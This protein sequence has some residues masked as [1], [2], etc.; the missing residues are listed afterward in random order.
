MIHPRAVFDAADAAAQ[1]IGGDAR[2]SLIVPVEIK[3]TR[4][5]AGDTQNQLRRRGQ[6]VVCLQGHE[7]TSAGGDKGVAG[8]SALREETDESPAALARAGAKVNIAVAADGSMKPEEIAVASHPDISNEARRVAG[9]EVDGIADIDRTA[10]DDSARAL[11]LGAAGLNDQCTVG[12]IS[13]GREGDGRQVIK[14]QTAAERGSSRK[15]NDRVGG[16]LVLDGGVRQDVGGAGVGRCTVDD[17]F[18]RIDVQAAALGEAAVDGQGAGARLGKRS[19][20]RDAPRQGQVAGGG[21]RKRAGLNRGDGGGRSGRAAEDLDIQRVVLVAGAGFPDA[22]VDGNGAR[23]ERP[24]D[25]RLERAAAGNTG[26]AGVGIGRSE[27]DMAAAVERERRSAVDRAAAERVAHRRRAGSGGVVED[28]AGGADAPALN[29]DRGIGG[30][31]C[32]QN[33]T[34][35]RVGDAPRA[36]DQIGPDDVA[37]HRVPSSG[38]GTGILQRGHCG[39]GGKDEVER[40]ANFAHGESS[41]GQ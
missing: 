26:T 6:R 40:R 34:R 23:A 22:V 8:V 17:E 27:D 15:G 35:I 11:N 16:R 31:S 19:S 32:E 25:L 36:M 5:T 3:R 14:D 28:H 1:G 41:V 7:G 24:A 18:A 21:A 29:R 20:A 10:A 12:A 37:A 4:T 9:I 39:R 33:V 30:R 2:H 38:R 13:A